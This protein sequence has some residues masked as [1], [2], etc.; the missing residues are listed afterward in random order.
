MKPIVLII[1]KHIIIWIS[2]SALHFFMSEQ[3]T[4]WLMP[5]YD[6]V[7]AWINVV[8]GGLCIIFL[9]TLIS[10]IITLKDFKKVLKKKYRMEKS[11][12]PPHFHA[13]YQEFTAEYDINTSIKNERN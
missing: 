1:L 3:I 12:N 2:L 10:F 4:K 5:G 6:S 8:I 13:I 9:L 7:Q 11:V